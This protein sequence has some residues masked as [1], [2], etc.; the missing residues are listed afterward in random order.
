MLE[1]ACVV[2]RRELYSQGRAAG[3]HRKRNRWTDAFGNGDKV[4]KKFDGRERTIQSDECAG[5]WG[6]KLIV[7]YESS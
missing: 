2:G 1:N 7:C 4:G 6:V 5:Y 3:R